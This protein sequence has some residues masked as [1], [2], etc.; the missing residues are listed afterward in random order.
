MIDRTTRKPDYVLLVT[1]AALVGT[2]LVMVY[3]ASFVEAYTLHETQF[4]Y[5][6]RQFV[7]AVLGIGAL[8]VIQRVHYN[9]WRRYSVPLLAGSLVLLVLVLVLPESMT[10]VNDSRSWIRFGGGLLSIQPSEIVKLTMIIYIADWLSQR[11]DRLSNVN[12][13]LIPFAVILGIVCGLVM[14]EPDR[15]TTLVLLVIGGVVYFAA[16]A[17][18]LHLLGAGGL[19][20]AAFWGLIQLANHNA[21]IAAFKDPWKYYNTFG[22]QPIHSLYALGSGGVFGAGLGQ[23][24]QKFQWLP[25]AHTDAIYAIVGEELG[26]LGTLAV[27]L[28]FGLIAY[29]GYRIAARSSDPFASLVAVGITTW[30][31][32]QAMINIA[33]TTSLIPFTGLTLPF[34]SYGGT[35]LLMCLVG[36]GVLLNISRHTTGVRHSEETAYVSRFRRSPALSAFLAQTRRATAL[37]PG[38][39]RNRRTRVP[40]AG[41]SRGPARRSRHTG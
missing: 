22:Y 31:F 28:A 35:S 7:G 40:G 36:V 19:G 4:Y 39:G 10:K 23:S 24:R 15:G 16:G 3:S 38:W 33:V 1:V 25:Q 27:L 13:G 32:F 14:L 29:R 26:L 6:V 41:R 21:R 18:L 12:Y 5:L 37:L 34:L 20:A 30:L 2:G 17:N 9:T 8:L 11:S